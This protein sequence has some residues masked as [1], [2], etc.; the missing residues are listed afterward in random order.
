[1]L[2]KDE[3]E[4]WWRREC[5][6]REVVQVALPLMISTGFFSLMLFADRMFLLWYSPDAMAAAM[7]A[8][9]LF[10]TLGC[11]PMGIAAYVNTFVAQYH[12]A[13]KPERIGVAMWQG[14]RIG[15]YCMPVFLA[16]IPVAPHLF[17]WFGH[18]NSLLWQESL[19]FQV[20]TLG[21]SANV[22]SGALSSF[23]TG[24]SQTRVVM[25]VDVSSALL[26]IVLDYIWIF[27]YLG[28]PEGGIEGAAWATVVALWFKVA[29]YA[30]I[31]THRNFRTR[32]A[33]WQGR[34][35]DW[36]LLRRLL[37]YGGPSGL[38]MLAE[39]GAF[40][41]IIL[42]MAELGKVPMAASTLAFTVNA[43]AFV[44]MFGVSIAVGT[45][46]GQQLMQGR[47][48]LASRA[49]WTA[50]SLSLVYTGAFAL[51]Y[52]L[53]PDVLLLGHRYGTDPREYQQIRDVAVVLLRF[54]AAFGLFD[55]MQMVFAG[56]IKG[57]GDTWFVLGGM[58]VLSTLAVS[59][60]W[61]GASLGGELIW[62]WC[63]VTGWVWGL[64]VTYFLRFRHGRWRDM[65]VIE[66]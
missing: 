16:M 38:Q 8:G 26:N 65:R 62:W 55:C 51:F 9:M 7:P 22:M 15:L 18:P 39:A 63:V 50:M 2:R 49:T 46:V 3:R 23:F 17:R 42:K 54:V 30:A 31:M 58:V 4:N 24:R 10:W 56:A 19:Y 61:L 41:L 32:Y 43:M 57:A 36:D 60:G 27:G 13:D 40:T 28:F 11:L 48:D 21:I 29:A 47:P 45:I 34:K 66:V 64:G 52:I 59:I 5:G 35:I 6:G 12:G 25:Y 37:I 1:M 44:P 14:C 33:L 53:A 20:L